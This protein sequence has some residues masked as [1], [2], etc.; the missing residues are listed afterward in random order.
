[1]RVSL[2]TTKADLSPSSILSEAAARDRS[3]LLLDVY[4]KSKSQSD[5]RLD[6]L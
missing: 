1:M 2:P 5:C 6:R 4:A 3:N